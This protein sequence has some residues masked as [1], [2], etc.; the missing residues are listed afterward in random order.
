M[1][2]GGVGGLVNHA[3]LPPCDS[4][5]GLDFSPNDFRVKTTTW[6]FMVV[7]GGSNG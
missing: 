7:H 6:I 4:G 5:G 2:V 1:G 3:V